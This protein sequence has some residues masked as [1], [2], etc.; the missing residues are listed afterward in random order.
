MAVDGMVSLAGGRVL[1]AILMLLPSLTTIGLPHPSLFPFQRASIDTYP[2]SIVLDPEN[3]QD[4][5]EHTDKL[6]VEKNTKAEDVI[7]LARAMQ[8]GMCGERFGTNLPGRI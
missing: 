4:E 3:I 7:N 6:V 8:Y 5:V 2:H 1:G